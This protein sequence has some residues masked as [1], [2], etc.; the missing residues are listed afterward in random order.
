MIPYVPPARDPYRRPD[1]PREGGARGTVV[2]R[3]ESPEEVERAEH[4]L[5]AARQRA[6][7][8]RVHMELESALRE[9]A[10]RSRAIGGLLV[11]ISCLLCWLSAGELER[12]YYHPRS[13]LMAG[14]ALFAGAWI[15]VMGAGGSTSMQTAPGWWRVGV[16][17]SFVA[18][19][20]FGATALV[21]LLRVL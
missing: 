16:A 18:G 17:V 2:R 3:A 6:Q 7:S 12:G 21:D 9:A 10:V 5:R 13:L 19:A 14:G 15:V 11:A 20:V 8:A 1:A 4:E